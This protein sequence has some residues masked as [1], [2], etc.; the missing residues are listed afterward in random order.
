LNELSKEKKIK[1]EVDVIAED[2]RTC[3]PMPITS[4]SE[5]SYQYVINI[6]IK[7]YNYVIIFDIIILFGLDTISNFYM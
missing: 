6:K 7:L 4:N 1:I 2:K 3:L 5:V